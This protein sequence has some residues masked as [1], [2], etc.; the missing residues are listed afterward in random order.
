M[1]GATRYL[2]L[3]SA[4]VAAILV[5]ELPVLGQ[6]SRGG[7]GG[8]GRQG[9]QAAPANL[10]EAPPIG[11]I[12]SYRVGAQKI[13]PATLPIIG[14][15]RIN[16]EKSDPGMKAQGRF[17]D[18]GTTIYTAEKGGIRTETFLFYPPKDDRYKTVFT[19]DGREYWFKLDGK[20]IYENPQGPNGLGQTVA[21]WLVDR[22]TLYRERMTKGVIDERVLYRVSPDGRTLV[23]TN[24][25]ADRDSGHVVWD[26]ITLPRR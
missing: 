1:R 5:H 25:G 8:E 26:R 13:D 18:T 23:W 3:A 4:I 6:G 19:D 9:G 7:R 21:M 2:A 20:N 22:N 16:F 10:P 12:G 11:F 15:W 24:F 17:K 14:A